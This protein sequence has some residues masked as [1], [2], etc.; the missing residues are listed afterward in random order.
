MFERGEALFLL[1]ARGAVH[2]LDG[3]SAS[4]ARAVLSILEAPHSRASLFEAL[5]AWVG[6]PVEPA[7]VVDELLALL[8]RCGAIEVLR[9]RV[10]RASPSGRGLRV[11]L[12]VTGAVQSVHSPW[13]AALLLAEGHDV[14][15]VMT[16]DAQR[17]CRPEALMAL[18]HQAP[19]TSL[20]D[21]EPFGVAPHIR[22]AEWAEL[23]VVAPAS[24]TTIARIAAGSCEE[25]VSAVCV[26][27]RAPVVLAPS[28]NAAMID[29]PSVQRNLERLREDGFVIVHPTVGHEVAQAPHERTA[30][31]GTMPSP[32]E[33]VA[34]LRAII[35]S[36]PERREPARVEPSERE[37]WERRYRDEHESRPWE[38][39]SLDE[40]LDARLDECVRL[41]HTH[42][43]DDGSEGALRALDLGCGTGLVATFLAS[44]GA[45]VTAIDLASSAIE[46]ARGRAGAER[47]RWI[48][49]DALRATLDG[50]FD[51]VHDRAL[52]HV[53]DPARRRALARRVAAWLAPG[54]ALVL[55]AHREDAPAELGTARLSARAVCELFRELE[56]ELVEPCAMRGPRGSE[57]AS[58]RYVLRRRRA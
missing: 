35:A 7:A 57:V 24:A 52:M 44:R 47:V 25:P 5:A 18:T 17:F 45:D 13:L 43:S 11:L 26:A 29:A 27:T 51:L 20:W 33:F 54:G 32:P 49:G 12:C 19:C 6:G 37:S 55:T 15:A 22:L 39:E 50:R 30:M 10:A 1:D 31:R 23:V 2:R 3:D 56:L 42:S 34:L 8:R 48:V 58:R 28:M 36:A 9:E 40:G 14:R 46:R 21:P 16:Q 38:A 41:L 53:L 4:L